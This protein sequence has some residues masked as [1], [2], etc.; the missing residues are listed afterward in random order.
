MPVLTASRTPAQLLAELERLV[1]VDWST[2]WAGVPEGADQ[3]TS[4][5]A[6][7]GWQPLWFQ[8]GL[9][10]RTAGGTRL[11]VA[12][13]APGRAVTRVEH[14]MWA[15]RARDV[16]ENDR[17]TRLALGSFTAHLAALRGVMGEPI[18]NGIQEDPDFPESPGSGPERREEQPNPHRTA[19][20]RFRT[21][22]APVFE[23][24]SDLGLGSQTAPVPADARIALIC[25]S[26]RE[27]PMP[28]PDRHA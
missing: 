14:T 3:R 27:Q 26:P 5:C 16:V 28:G 19:V 23:L 21:P 22:G 17:V 13:S 9:W 15:A 25:H 11:H 20:W 6:A 18:G 2:V 12:A 10:V 8:A 1:E 7:L 4:W 24:R